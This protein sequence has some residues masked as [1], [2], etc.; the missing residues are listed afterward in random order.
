MHSWFDRSGHWALFGGYYIAGVR[1]FTA[2][3]AGASKLDFRIFALYAWGG[4]ATWVAV[5]LTLGYV[6]GEQ[7]RTVAD[8]VH[9]YLHYASALAIALLVLYFAGRRWMQR[10]KG[11]GGGA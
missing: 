11:S 10:R 7:W 8:M 2:I 1:H 9:R 6:I 3:I 5:F 4:A